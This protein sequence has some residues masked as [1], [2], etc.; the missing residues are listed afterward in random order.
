MKRFVMFGLSLAFFFNVS[1]QDDPVLMEINGKQIKRSEFE[2]IYNKN[3]SNSSVPEKKN[4]DEYVDLFIN[5]KLKVAEAESLGMDTAKSFINEYKSYRAQLAK[6]YLTDKEADEEFVRSIYNHMSENIEAS[7]ILIEC[8]ENSTPADTLAAYSKAMEVY[9][10]L[11]GGADFVETARKYSDDP[12]VARNGGSLGYFGALQMVPD[13]EMAA[14]SLQPGEISMPVRSRFGYHIIK[15]TNRRPDPGKVRVA[16]IFKYIPQNASEAVR[17]AA[18]ASMD[19]VYNAILE[20]ADFGEMAGKFSDDKASGRQGGNLGWVGMN[21]TIPAFEDKIFSMK[22]GE[23][24]EPFET[25][26]GIHIVK[27]TDTKIVGT[28]EEERKGIESTLAKMGENDKGQKALIARLKKEY[29]ISDVNSEIFDML[30]NLAPKSELGDSLYMAALSGRDNV[31][32]TFAGKEYG[33]QDFMSFV[34]G[35]KRINKK[36]RESALYSLIDVYRDKVVLDYEDTQL[37]KKYP[38]FALLANEYRDGILLFNISNQEVWGK[39]SSDEEGLAKYFKKNKRRYYW[40]EPHFKGVVVKCVSDTLDSHL[41][42]LFDG[43]PMDKWA[44]LAV[45]TFNNDS[46]KLVNVRK[47]LFVKGDNAVVDFYEF[48]GE[49]YQPDTNYPHAFVYGKMLKKKPEDFR[50]VRGPVSAD[51]QTF[52]EKKWMKYLRK[53]YADKIIIHEDV[54]KT[55]N[56]H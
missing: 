44:G 39:A 32:F 47:G 52:L 50:D 31:L 43:E 30:K 10:Q 53:K 48:N 24:S 45:K 11:K 3:N 17:E 16:H 14:Y 49:K 22:D 15:V 35:Y 25:P 51:Y 27:K 28:F 54:L 9:N 20:G 38:D 37:E 1:A 46:V 12:S 42:E 36:A 6:S 26:I 7:H 34:Q 4:L 21:M 41:R 40:D 23:L 8:R 55:V 19:S 33:V 13:F 56:N 2:Y 29:G 5:F 18:K